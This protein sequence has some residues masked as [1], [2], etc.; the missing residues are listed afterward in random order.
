[1]YRFTAIVFLFML[2]TV[3]FVFAQ[4]QDND[5]VLELYW[6]SAYG[7]VN[8][9][10]V[11]VVI[12]DAPDDIDPSDIG[13][14][15]IVGIYLNTDQY[16]VPLSEVPYPLPLVGQHGKIYYVIVNAESAYGTD[17]LT[18]T[19]DFEDDL[20]S[21]SVTPELLQEFANAA[22]PL[23]V[24]ATIQFTLRDRYLFSG[25]DGL[26]YG[27]DLDNGDI[28][29]GLKQLFSVKGYPLSDN[30]TV[31]VTKLSER[32]DVV[33]GAAT[34]DLKLSDVGWLNIYGLSK[35]KF[36]VITDVVNQKTYPVRKGV[37]N[38]LYVTDGTTGPNS[39]PSDYVWCLL[40]Q[41]F[42]PGRPRQT[43]GFG[44]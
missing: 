38:I 21:G 40:G 37:D 5:T 22:V 41:Q 33:D 19:L 28:P 32:W 6:G 11:F 34:Y 7:D 17:L 9:Y 16:S 26:V 18:L 30:A 15:T 2:A 13:S 31:S 8:H 27:V 25:P 4:S 44:G 20:D 43:K 3:A 12:V 24:D 35:A 36:W 14:Y 42:V 1:M 39:E 23:S 10:N 29:D